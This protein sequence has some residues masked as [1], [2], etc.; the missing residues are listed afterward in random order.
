[1]EARND[2]MSRQH[3]LALPGDTLADLAQLARDLGLQ[4]QLPF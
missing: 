3:G 4:S 1:L 2:A